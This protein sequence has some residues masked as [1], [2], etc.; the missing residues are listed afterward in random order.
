VPHPDSSVSLVLASASPR[1]HELLAQLGVRFRS[2][3]AE[4]DEKRL[5][6]EEAVS[7]AVRVATA[8]GRAVADLQSS[9]ELPVLGADTVVTLDGYVLQKPA[10][11]AEGVEMLMQLAGREHHVIS[12]VAVVHG[13][14]LRTSVNRTA[15]RFSDITR[16]QANRYWDTGEPEDKAGGYAIQG[17]GAVFVAHIEGSYSAVMGLPLFETARLLAQCGLV[18]C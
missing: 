8:K 15:V 5:A 2:T 14:V 13:G 1:R 16:D 11:R 6:G 7:Y 17:L 4:I 10:D 9:A 12:A 18:V 3:A